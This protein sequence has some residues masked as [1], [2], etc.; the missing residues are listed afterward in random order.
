MSNLYYGKVVGI[1]GNH[2]GEPINDMMGPTGCLYTDPA[3]HTVAWS[4]PG[5]GC[6]RF[7]LRNEKRTLA[8]YRENCDKVF[9]QPTGVSQH[10]G[11]KVS[12]LS[13]L[14]YHYVNLI[15]LIKIFQFS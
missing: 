10:N 15:K 12:K 9:F 11:K 13:I 5:V 1:C 7:S 3:L 14:Q 6:S 2:D 8:E 4:T